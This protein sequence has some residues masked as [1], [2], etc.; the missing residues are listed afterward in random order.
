MLAENYTLEAD[1]EE[2]LQE[3]VRQFGCVG[4]KRKLM[5]NINPLTPNRRTVRHYKKSL[6]CRT[7]LPYVVT[8]VFFL[9]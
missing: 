4:K 1:S 2:W 5:V 6:G 3:L 9:F 8:K 7:N